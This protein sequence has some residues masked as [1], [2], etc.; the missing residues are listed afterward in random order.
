MS[1]EKTVA[2]NLLDIKAV[3]LQPNDP[4]TW[5]SGIKSPI[6]CDN[7]LVLSF[8]EK[9][10]VVVQGFVELIQK[11]Y[12]D[13]EVIVGTATAG[14][15]WGAMVADK[16]EK[17][18]GYVRSSNKTHGKGN[19]IE[20]KIEKGAKVVVVE[21]LISTGGSVKDVILSLREA[22]AEVLGVVAIFTYLLPASNELFDSIAC[23]FKT[24]SNYDVLIDVALE[25][26]YIKENDLEKLKAWKKDPK[27]ESWMKK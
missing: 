9:R 1:I 20:G 19:K 16:M 2:K 3:S 6:Y 22:G 25:N 7:R 8:P 18:F 17:P 27:D 26:A 13:A 4:F 5:A 12:S 15:P 10:S 14:I 11:E 24:L 21:D 23:S